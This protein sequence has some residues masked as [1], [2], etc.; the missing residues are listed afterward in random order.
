MWS[1]TTTSMST[2]APAPAEA[3]TDSLPVSD[4][5]NRLALVHEHPPLV[6][7]V[8]AL[9]EV[10]PRLEPLEDE[11]ATEELLV[12]Q[13]DVGRIDLELR[14]KGKEVLGIGMEARRRIDEARGGAT[15]AGDRLSNL[16][17][18]QVLEHLPADH[19]VE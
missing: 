2:W 8:H 7:P 19:Q 1:P 17:H 16:E 15:D 3:T 14:G 5:I 12:E 9:L 13:R 11:K 10:G 18:G 4:L 6:A